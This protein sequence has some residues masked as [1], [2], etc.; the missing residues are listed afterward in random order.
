MKNPSWIC[1]KCTR[2]FTRKWNVNCRWCNKHLVGL[3]CIIPFSEYLRNLQYPGS[4]RSPN[5]SLSNQF[6]IQN[7]DTDHINENMN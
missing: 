2:H 5:G 1:S 7:N 4:M 6:P 3:Y